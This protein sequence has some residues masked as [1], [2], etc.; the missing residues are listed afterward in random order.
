[1]VY[2][3]VVLVVR[4]I[5]KCALD[6]GTST[7]S[8]PAGGAGAGLAVYGFSIPEHTRIL[9]QVLEIVYRLENPETP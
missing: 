2:A 4:G 6:R 1:M 9:L 3:R 7:W 8:A 5:L